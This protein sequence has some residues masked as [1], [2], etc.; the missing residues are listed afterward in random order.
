MWGNIWLKSKPGVGTSVFFTLTFPKAAKDVTVESMQITARDPDPMAIW[1]P[2]VETGGSQSTSRSDFN[3][4]SL[5]PRNELRICIAEDNPVN[6]KIAVSF[7]KKLGFNSEAY[8]D[9]KQA[10]DALR[11]RSKEGRHFH[12]VLMDVQMPVLDGYDATRTIRKDEDPAV[13]G[14]L[15]IAMTA[16]AIRG[17]REK[18]LEAGMNNYLAKPV[19]AAVLKAMLEGYLSQPP[20]KIPHLQEAAN[21]L[22]KKIVKEVQQDKNG[23]E[24]EV[25]RTSPSPSRDSEMSITPRNEHI[26]QDPFATPRNEHIDQDPFTT[27][28][29]EPLKVERPPDERR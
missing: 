9:G 22:A 3:D 21:D 19:R 23:Q 4:V 6:Q 27:P 1:E 14:V 17:D 25:N 16:S 15:I 10:V 2:N 18:C 12:L 28:K 24:V 26:S 20:K 8:N 11:L 29:D 7:V 5:V 13:R